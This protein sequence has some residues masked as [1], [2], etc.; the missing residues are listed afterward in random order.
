MPARNPEGNNLPI[1]YPLVF[2]AWIQGL[3]DEAEEWS[4]SSEEEDDEDHA[5]P[6]AGPGP[7]APDPGLPLQGQEVPLDLAPELLAQGAVPAA[8]GFDPG[9]SSST[10]AEEVE[11]LEEAGPPPSPMFESDESDPLS[12]E[13]V[14]PYL[15]LSDTEE[16]ELDDVEVGGPPPSP[17]F[18]VEES[19]PPPYE[20]PPPPYEGPPPL[21]EGPPPPYESPPPPTKV[22]HATSLSPIRRRMT[23]M[24][25]RTMLMHVLPFF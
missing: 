23:W 18:G 4:W 15:L 8:S 10:V 3:V 16:D 7:V 14:P 25:W 22:P 21:Y 17:V 5:P 13:G 12:F 20:G 19:P 11:D 6:V 1:V 2:V 9:A 24:M